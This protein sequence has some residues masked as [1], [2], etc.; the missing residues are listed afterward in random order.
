MTSGSNISRTRP[1]LSV[2]RTSH[3][4]H[5]T[6][7]MPDPLHIA[8]DG[9]NLVLFPNCTTVVIRKY[10]ATHTYC[11]CR[12]RENLGTISYTG[13]AGKYTRYR[14]I[15]CSLDGNWSTQAQ[16]RAIYGSAGKY[17]RQSSMQLTISEPMRNHF[18]TMA[19]ELKRYSSVYYRVCAP[20]FYDNWQAVLCI[21]WYHLWRKNTLYPQHFLLWKRIIAVVA[22]TLYVQCD[23]EKN[24]RQ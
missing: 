5:A 10:L 4:R 12:R 6:A 8:I 15:Y 20:L 14:H 9:S 3:L 21:G 19:L 1:S 18:W 13:T 24:G 11:N 22:S 16:F 17:T 7:S 23:S 2:T